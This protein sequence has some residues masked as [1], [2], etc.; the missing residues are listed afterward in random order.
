VVWV[1]GAPLRA[2][3]AARYGGGSWLLRYPTDGSPLVF[4]RLPEP[5]MEDGYQ[6]RHLAVDDSGRVYLLLTLRGGMAIY[7]R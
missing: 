4:E 6:A 7:R 1:K 5:A 3:D 2:D